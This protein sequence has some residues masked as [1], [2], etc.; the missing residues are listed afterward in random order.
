[1]KVNFH[2]ESVLHY[3]NAHVLALYVIC[4]V[5]L[6]VEI[7]Q[8]PSRNHDTRERLKIKNEYTTTSWNL[9]SQ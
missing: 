8:Y 1:M 9:L 5:E 6:K 4:A 7:V 3:C 2:S